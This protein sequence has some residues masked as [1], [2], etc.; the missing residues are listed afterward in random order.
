MQ[1]PGLYRKLRAVTIHFPDPWFKKRHKKRRVVQPDLVASIVRH[2]P[3]GGWLFLQTDVLE[4]AEAARDTIV[5]EAG[6]SFEDQNAQL[7]I[8]DVAKPAWLNKAATER[9]RACA[10]LG[11]PVYRRLFVKKAVDED[12]QH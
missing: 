11:R 8:W 6:G 5:A 4:L 3:A 10:Q 1:F 12:L 2:L 7:N 9:E